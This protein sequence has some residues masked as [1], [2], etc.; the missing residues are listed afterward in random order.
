[1]QGSNKHKYQYGAN[2]LVMC[3]LSQASCTA[4]QNYLICNMPLS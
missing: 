4:N 3:S 2:M 1:M